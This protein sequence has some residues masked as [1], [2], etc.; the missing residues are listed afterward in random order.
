MPEYA[1][2]TKTRERIPY[3]VVRAR[4]MTNYDIKGDAE[5]VASRLL[6]EGAID[7]ATMSL[8][9]GADVAT[10]LGWTT[11]QLANVERSERE[12]WEAMVM[13][14][15]IY[16]TDPVDQTRLFDASPAT[17]VISPELPG[18]VG[19]YIGMRIIESYVKSHPDV[20]LEELLQPEFALNRDNFLS[21]GYS[22]K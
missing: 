9:D 13:R 3:D 19:R 14:N 2:I 5:D 22:S 20:T 7:Y 15:L 4:L 1:R 8:V 16:S 17:A 10:M 18:G 21:A 12:I 6:H 11:E